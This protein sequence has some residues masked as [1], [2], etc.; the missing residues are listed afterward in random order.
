MTAHHT[1]WM[2]WP[3]MKPPNDERDARLEQP[4]LLAVARRHEPVQVGHDSVL[5]EHD[6]QRQEDDDDQVADYAQAEQGDVRQ[7]TDE[8]V[9]QVAQVV[10]Q[11][12]RAATRIEL[13][14]QALQAAG[15]RRQDFRQ[16]RLEA[17]QLGDEVADRVRQA[18]RPRSG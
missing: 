5:V 9:A 12:L 10:E 8:L 4:R 14:T 11:V 7:R 17:G 2:A 13:E 6:E 18:D 1:P 15:D 16:A 3:R